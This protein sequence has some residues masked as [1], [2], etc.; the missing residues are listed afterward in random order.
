[1]QII[2]VFI[3]VLFLGL[4]IFLVYD[5]IRRYRHATGTT[6][7][8]LIVAG[9]DSATILWAKI[10]LIFSAVAENADSFADLIQQPQ[11]K[12]YIDMAF[13]PQ[14]FGAMLAGFMI[15]SWLARKR[16]L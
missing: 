7:D 10:S 12:P 4:A 1:M 8:R 6:W 13:T 3:E 2:R 9:H 16:T 11:L 14:A 5:I 15:I